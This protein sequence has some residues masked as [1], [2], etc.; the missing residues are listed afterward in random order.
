M[1]D[2]NRNSRTSQ[3]LLRNQLAGKGKLKIPVIPKFEVKAGD[4]KLL[5]LIGFGKTHLEDHNHL[6]RMVHFLYDYRFEGG[7]KNPDSDPEN[8]SVP[9]PGFQ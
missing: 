7:R 4:F 9:L 5:L 8:A 6:G 1:T 2:E 3:A